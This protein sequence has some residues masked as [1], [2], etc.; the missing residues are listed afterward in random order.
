MARI[1]AVRGD[2]LNIAV[3]DIKV[4]LEDGSFYTFTEAD[5]FVFT[6]AMK[7]KEPILSKRRPGDMQL[8][9]DTLLVSFSPEETARLRCLSYEFDCKVDFGGEGR[10]IYTIVRGEMQVYETVTKAGGGG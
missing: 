6:I 10:D 8:V 3:T 5:Q 1:K 2:T 9:G 7:N 4:E